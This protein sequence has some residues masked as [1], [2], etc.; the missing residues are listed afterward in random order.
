M[1]HFAPDKTRRTMKTSFYIKTA[2]CTAALLTCVG[3]QVYTVHPGEPS[4]TPSFTLRE[5]AKIFSSLPMDIE[6]LQEV[7]RAVSSSGSGG[8]DEE[9]MLRDL[10]ASP[11][12]GV[13]EAPA[14]RAEAAASYSRPLRS[15]L[16]EYFQGAGPLSKAGGEADVQAYLQ[17]LTESGM[18]IYWPYSEEWNGSDYPIIT[19]NPGYGAETNYGYEL[20]F[21]ED[22][23][24]IV[25]SVLVDEELARRRP[26][27]VINDNNDSAYT[28]ADFIRHGTKSTVTS[29]E[30]GDILKFRSIKALRNFDS[31]FAG[32]SEFFIKCGSV[33]GF[34][35]STD[36]ELRLYSP[37]V[38][39]FMIVVKRSEVGTEKFFDTL[40]MTGFTD[41]LEKLAFLVTEDDGGTHTSW[42]CSATVKIKSKS[43]GFD[44]DLPY[45]D[46]DDIVWRGQLD[47]DWFRN[48]R[49][50]SANFGQVELSF[51]LQ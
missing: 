19:F 46:K 23:A 40:I 27:W 44:I 38:T 21:N 14:T 43:Y 41:Q 48:Q 28:P 2:F 17:A 10:I 31:W 33:C 11:G 18:Q 26:V 50:A 29:A 22:G 47:A 24:F 1:V 30:S 3:C 6:N 37:S 36:A 13:G 9:Y 12:A 15:L 8:Y 35:A 16:E 49:I 34:N 25:D 42:K 20:D 39:D 5:V 32:G 51:E 4:D 45:N 7:H